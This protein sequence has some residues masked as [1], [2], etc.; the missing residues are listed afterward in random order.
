MKFS[1]N[2]SMV[3]LEISKQHFPLQKR[4]RRCIQDLEAR[5]PTVRGGGGAAAEGL[6]QFLFGL[7]RPCLNVEIESVHRICLV[8]DS[9]DRFYFGSK[10]P[11]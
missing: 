10:R 11:F 7:Y 8:T 3:T 9:V 6:Q 2:H 1:Y 4:R 5:K